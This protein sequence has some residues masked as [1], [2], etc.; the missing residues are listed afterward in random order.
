MWP[1]ATIKSDAKVIP[2]SYTNTDEGPLQPQQPII[3]IVR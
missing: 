3:N 2:Q 1:T